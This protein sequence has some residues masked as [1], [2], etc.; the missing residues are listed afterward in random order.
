M[1]KMKFPKLKFHEKNITKNT[2]MEKCN[3]K[4]DIAWPRY[5]VKNGCH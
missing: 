3:I 2:S 5:G 1:K 4:I